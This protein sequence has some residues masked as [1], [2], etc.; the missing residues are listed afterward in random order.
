MCAPVCRGKFILSV[1]ES[2]KSK[3]IRPSVRLCGVVDSARESAD[4]GGMIKWAH[5]TLLGHWGHLP[6]TAIYK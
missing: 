5:E 3:C 2:D 6:R 4:W 1:S